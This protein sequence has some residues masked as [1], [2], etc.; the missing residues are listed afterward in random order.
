MLKLKSAAALAIVAFSAPIANAQAAVMG[1]D[2]AACAA[3]ARHSAA[4]VIVDGFK[5]REGTVRVRAFP[6][7]S[8]DLFRKEGQIDRV[9]MPV[10]AHGKA[11]ICVPL[12][13]PGAYAFDVRHDAN[14]NGDTD[15]ADG[16]GFSGNPK[17][18]FWQVVSKTRPPVKDAAIAIGNGVTTVPI[19]LNY[20]QG[21]SVG[22]VRTAAR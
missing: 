10:P 7:N 13:G 21:L 8:P 15:K 16:G 1:P 4:L 22:P 12:P 19:I 6:A 18:T 5:N 9:A 20:M 3:S 11:A 14:D 2:V 17:V